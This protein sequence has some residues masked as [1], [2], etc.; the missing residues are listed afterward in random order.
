MKKL[1]YALTVI[2]FTLSACGPV[3]FVPTATSSPIP[4]L[5]PAPTDSDLV[6]GNAFVKFIRTAYP[7]EFPIAV[8]ACSQRQPAHP[9]QSTAGGCQP[10]RTRKTRLPWMFFQ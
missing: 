6:R 3:T 7:G 8:Y 4:S 1:M 5:I 2:V 10:A 9:L